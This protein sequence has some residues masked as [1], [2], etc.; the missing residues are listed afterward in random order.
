[1]AMPSEIMLLCFRFADA[2][3]APQLVGQALLQ[4]AYN[5]MCGGSAETAADWHAREECFDRGVRNMFVAAAEDL[6]ELAF[7]QDVRTN[8]GDLFWEAHSR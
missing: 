1:M 4:P 3:V 2:D 8:V 6:I 7:V 5:T